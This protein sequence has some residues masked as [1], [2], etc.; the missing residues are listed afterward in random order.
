MTGA[1]GDLAPEFQPLGRKLERP[2]PKPASHH[3]APDVPAEKCI[4]VGP[5]GKWFTNDPRNGAVK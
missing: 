5:D 1:R 4:E 3:P 2:A